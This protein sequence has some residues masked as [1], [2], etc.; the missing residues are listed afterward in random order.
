MRCAARLH[1]YDF[2]EWPSMRALTLLE[3]LLLPLILALWEFVRIA[4][5]TELRKVW[6]VG[7]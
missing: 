1:F 5:R 2:Y 7:V 3:A 6:R 4:H